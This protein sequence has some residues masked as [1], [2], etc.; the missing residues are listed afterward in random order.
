MCGH[1]RH[2][3]SVAVYSVQ[4]IQRVANG[5]LLLVSLLS[6]STAFLNA[7][8]NLINYALKSKQKLLILR[9]KAKRY[10]SSLGD[11]VQILG[12]MSYI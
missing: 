4:N 7:L 8:L 6:K 10:I 5:C 1:V 2:V 12:D 3:V 11:K 9:S